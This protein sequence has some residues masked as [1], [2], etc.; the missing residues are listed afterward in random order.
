MD[1]RPSRTRYGFERGWALCIGLEAETKSVIQ[2]RRSRP[3][4][5]VFGRSVHHGC[6][7]ARML[8]VRARGAGR[9]RVRVCQH[10]KF[11]NPVNRSRK[12]GSPV[13]LPHDYDHTRN[14]EDD[15]KRRD[16]LKTLPRHG[17]GLSGPHVLTDTDTWDRRALTHSHHGKRW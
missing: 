15:A 17:P 12:A 13:S 10:Q 8:V 7:H 1:C 2:P 5:V 4:V 14:Y 6:I 16:Q 11:P 3:R 9:F